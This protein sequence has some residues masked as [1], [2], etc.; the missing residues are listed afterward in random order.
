MIRKIRST[1]AH[2]WKSISN[3]RCGQDNFV[4][5]TNRP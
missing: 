3:H 5:V 2:N 4:T 1:R